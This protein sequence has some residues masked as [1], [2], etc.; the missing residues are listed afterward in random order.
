[1]Y[2]HSDRY[3]C[4]Y[5]LLSCVGVKGEGAIGPVVRG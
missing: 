2:T 4:L 3:T 5:E 1:M